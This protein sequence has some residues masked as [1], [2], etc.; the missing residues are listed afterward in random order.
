MYHPFIIGEKIYLRGLERKDL[1][2]DYFDWLNDSEVTRFLD[3]GFL[4]NSMEKMDDYYGNV[5]LSPDNV[6]LA[7]IDKESDRHVG[8]I[9]L[10][11]INWITRVAPLGIMVGNKEYWGRGYGTEAIQLVVNHAFGRLNLHKINAGIAADNTASVGAF[12]KAGF[13]IEGRAKSQF[14]LDGDYSDSLYVGITRD[15]YL[16][17]FRK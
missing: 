15:D 7:I 6:M 3:S 14:Y 1:E 17:R 9:K 2:G 16:K 12:G 13:E 11:P 10:G 5:A 8:N 4:P